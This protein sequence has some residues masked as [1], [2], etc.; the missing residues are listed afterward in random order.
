[1]R[2]RESFLGGEGSR[3][4]EERAKP[5]CGQYYQDAPVDEA[6]QTTLCHW[7]PTH[8]MY[9]ARDPNEYR[10]LMSIRPLRHVA[11]PTVALIPQN[12]LCA[13]VAR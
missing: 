1:M 12:L 8:A 4:V 5:D 9:I 13:A 3:K 11:L 6:V 7:Q 2:R 10:K